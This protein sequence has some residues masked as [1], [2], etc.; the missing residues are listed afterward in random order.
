MPTMKNLNN[1]IYAIV[2][3]FKRKIVDEAMSLDYTTQSLET[4]ENFFKMSGLIVDLTNLII[5]NV[6]QKI[7]DAGR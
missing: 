2:Y 6:V 7:N 4:H 5:K 3:L 1:Y